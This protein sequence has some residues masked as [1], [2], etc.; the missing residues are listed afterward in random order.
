MSKI[1]NNVK[2]S[3]MALFSGSTLSPIGAPRRTRTLHNS[4]ED[5]CDIH[6]T[7]GAKNKMELVMGLGPMTF[8]LRR[9]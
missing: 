4:S 6:F 2:P 7:M 1:K 9:K 8:R 3:K 5:Y